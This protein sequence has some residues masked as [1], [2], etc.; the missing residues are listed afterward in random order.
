MSFILS[1]GSA[2]VINLLQDPQI[3]YIG[4]HLVVDPRKQT[5]TYDNNE[6]KVEP[7]L[8]QLL[9]LLVSEQG[10]IVSRERIFETVWPGM[11]VTQNS[12]NQSISKLRKLVGDNSKSPH[13]I[14]TNPR[15]GYSFIEHARLAHTSD[16]N[17]SQNL[18]C[19]PA[20]QSSQSSQYADTALQTSSQVTESSLPIS[21]QH[22]KTTVMVVIVF[23]L[24]II[25]V[26]CISLW[27]KPKQ[28]IVVSPAPVLISSGE[29]PSD[30]IGHAF[31]G[32]IYAG[33]KDYLADENI[34][35]HFECSTLTAKQLCPEDYQFD[36]SQAIEIK[37][38]L[39]YLGDTVKLNL[40]IDG[41]NSDIELQSTS[42][43]FSQ[44]DQELDDLLLQL[45]DRF[46][47]EKNK[48]RVLTPALNRLKQPHDP[49]LP[50]DRLQLAA[51]AYS[52]GIEENNDFIA[53]LKASTLSCGLDC[54]LV[55]G[56]YGRVLL[57]KYVKDEQSQTLH[58][59]IEYLLQGLP[60]QLS[61][62]RLKLAVAYA[63]DG[64][65]E[66][67][68]QLYESLDAV[69]FSDVKNAL[70]YYLDKKYRH[71]T[72]AT[73]NTKPRNRLARFLFF[74]ADEQAE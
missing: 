4:G 67:S 37:P 74:K 28:V 36:R 21:L 6:Q 65:L 69:S 68:Q 52:Q 56:A 31:S 53:K 44:L 34:E 40:V 50:I 51:F 35:V 58:L 26:V 1:R 59:A 72:L 54:P 41:V 11:V 62:N 18:P 27:P 17:V 8:I 3:F 43:S 64:Q 24:F 14:V 16:D 30:P 71:N 2:F 33:L 22:M 29:I 25:C 7:Q 15:K 70:K 19:L 57:N 13:I 49:A 46:T 9:L 42:L 12:L 48:K 23:L 38:I 55:F 45:L 47:D 66:V 20:Q 61:E 5:I 60:E 63:L 73:Q 32:F 39:R 10:N